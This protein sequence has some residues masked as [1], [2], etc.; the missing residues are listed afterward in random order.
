MAKYNVLLVLNTLQKKVIIAGKYDVT[1]MGLIWVIVGF[2]CSIKEVVF[3]S[4][5]NYQI[6]NGVYWH[7]IL[8]L[9]LYSAYPAEY[10]DVNHYGPIF[11]II[12][13]PF[14]LLPIK[15]GA[16]AWCAANTLILYFA[17][18]KLPVS[19][20]AKVII[21]LVCLVEFTISIQNM[22]ANPLVASLLIF[23]FLLI[24]KKQ[25]FWA[26][27]LIVIGFLMK[28]YGIVGLLFFMFSKR[29]L[30]FIV[31]FVGW[32]LLLFALPMVLSSPTYIVQ[33]YHHWYQVLVEKNL[34]NSTSLMQNISVQGMLTRITGITVGIN[35]YV[36]P[37]AAIA[38]LLPLLRIKQY[39]YPLYKLTYLCILL[40][41]TVLYSTSAES[42]TY[43]IAIVGTAIAYTLYPSNKYTI[44]FLLFY[45]LL[46][47][48]SSGDLF[49]IYVREHYIRPYSLK[50]LPSAI[51]W[52][53][54]LIQLYTT[55]FATIT[56]RNYN[57]TLA[58]D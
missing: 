25:D 36:L 12:I 49:P 48:I 2:L 9:N 26:T 45:V 18:M 31:S 37:A 11:S 6:F 15:V 30:T 28:V 19:S 41:T 53:M 24:E 39:K 32:F 43:I 58:N 1:V 42:S 5:N 34:Q 23:T 50:A 21:L 55:N 52:L 56:V 40:I 29:K 44:G 38:L 8:Q 35:T 3:H 7:T 20:K 13:A 17:I 33:C 57:H 14:A 27:L 46:T 16:V 10:F 4:I 47:S 54:L 51:V 22:Q